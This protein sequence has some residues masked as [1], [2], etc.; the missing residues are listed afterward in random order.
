[1][2][3]TMTTA[4]ADI[5]LVLLLAAAVALAFSGPGNRDL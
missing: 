2:I 4:A 5:G 1:V 3:A